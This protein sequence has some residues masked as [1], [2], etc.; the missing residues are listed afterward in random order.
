MDNGILVLGGTATYTI[1]VTNTHPSAT[2]D[3]DGIQ[4]Q[5]PGSPGVASFVA[6][7]LKCAYS[8][9]TLQT[10]ATTDYY[11]T[12]GGLLSYE[13]LIVLGQKDSATDEYVCQYKVGISF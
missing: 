12:A 6:G 13:N 1:T 4:D 3:L 2:L 8:G 11:V 7:S 10:V 5:L 9:N